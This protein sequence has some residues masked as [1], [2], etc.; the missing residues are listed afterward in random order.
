MLV[1][2]KV[3]F[4][5]GKVFY[6]VL[7][8]AAQR[9]ERHLLVKKARQ[10]GAAQERGGQRLFVRLLELAQR[11]GHPVARLRY[12]LRGGLYGAGYLPYL[13]VFLGNLSGGQGD[14]LLE[15]LYLQVQRFDG[16]LQGLLLRG[17]RGEVFLQQ[18]DFGLKPVYL[19]VGGV[20]LGLRFLLCFCLRLG[21]GVGVGLRDRKRGGGAHKG[22][23]KQETDKH[24]LYFKV[25]RAPK[26]CARVRAP[27]R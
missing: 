2:L 14:A 22:E 5:A 12:L 20:Y 24:P 10:R 9:A 3:V 27:C 21:G 19:R 18:G 25:F 23:D 11:L 8:G 1:F 17:G 13:F 15:L 6:P 26:Q 16:V 7:Q 4:Q